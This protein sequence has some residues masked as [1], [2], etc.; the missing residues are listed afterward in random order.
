MSQI[1]RRLRRTKILRN[2]ASTWGR[3]IRVNEYA[4]EISCGLDGD[5]AVHFVTVDDDGDNIITLPVMSNNFP[6]ILL[7]MYVESQGKCT[8]MVKLCTVEDEEKRS[9]FYEKLNEYNNRFSFVTF[10]ISEAGHLTMINSFIVN[11][12]NPY[13]IVKKYITSACSIIEE[14]I[15]EV[16]LLA[17]DREN[18]MQMDEDMYDDMCDEDVCDEEDEFLDDFE[19]VL[20]VTEADGYEESEEE[21][22]GLGE[23]SFDEP[24][25]EEEESL[26]SDGVLEDEDEDDLQDG[27]EELFGTKE[28]KKSKKIS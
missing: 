13:D 5:E 26:I 14:I 12:Q 19:L 3:R 17:W 24:F 27:A 7:K 9:K 6:G 15:Q 4:R 18:E 23:F 11:S 25:F 22:E 28:K 21:N 10:S 8:I 20:P 16:L 1:I 2:N